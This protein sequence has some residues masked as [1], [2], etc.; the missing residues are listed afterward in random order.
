MFISRVGLQREGTSHRAL[1]AQLGRNAERDCGHALVS[2][3]F[4][5][6]SAR[7]FIWR[8]ENDARFRAIVV[9]PR[10]P[11]DELGIF[12]TMTKRYD[13]HLNEGETLTFSLRANP[14][15]RRRDEH[16]RLHKHDVAMHAI[17]S[18]DE[19]TRQ[20][21]RWDAAREAV[22]KW[23]IAQGVRHGFAPVKEAFALLGSARRQ[24]ERGAGRDVAKFTAFDI[25]GS[26]V[27]RDAAALC[28][29][30]GSGI[31]SSRAYGCGLLLVR[32]P[33]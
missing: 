19:E 26:M 33:P 17:R 15:V 21:A 30:L 6:E 8:E 32:R 22:W 27:V 29:A 14:V 25:S 5:R 20:L 11:M 24:V 23:L 7:S 12:E 18:M 4:P 2:M 28:R 16:G 10:E 3:L 9:S 13:P 1:A 31:G